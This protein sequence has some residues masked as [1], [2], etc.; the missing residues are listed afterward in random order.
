MY[1]LNI[2]VIKYW[3]NNISLASKG[4]LTSDKL[5]VGNTPLLRLSNLENGGLKLYAKL[6]WANPFGSLK[7][8]AAYWMIK[9]LK[10]K[11]YFLKIKK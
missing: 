8:R 4:L 11:D 3:I 7:D 1:E 5:K 9:W 6:E 2:N 10:T